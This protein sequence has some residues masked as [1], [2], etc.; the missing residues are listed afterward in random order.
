MAIGPHGLG[1][2]VPSSAIPSFYTRWAIPGLRVDH[3]AHR[4]APSGHKQPSTVFR[5]LGAILGY[6]PPRGS[7]KGKS[8]KNNFRFDPKD[9]TE[10]LGWI[11]QHVSVQWYVAQPAQS[12]VEKSLI[13]ECKPMLNTVHNDEAVEELADARKECRAIAG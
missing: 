11:Q 13:Q 12:R 8:N 9:H 7:L 4:S 2:Y 1:S 5:G 6:R 10:I 3:L